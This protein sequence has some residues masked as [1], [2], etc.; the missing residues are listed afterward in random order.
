MHG[1]VLL[2]SLDHLPTCARYE[3]QRIAV[4]AGGCWVG[5]ELAQIR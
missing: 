5:G 3:P 1:V 2:A 4:H